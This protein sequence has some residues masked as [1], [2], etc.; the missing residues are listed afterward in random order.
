MKTRFYLFSLSFFCSM[1]TAGLSLCRAQVISVTCYPDSVIKNVS[2]HPIGIN[3]DFFMDGGR[4]PN[5]KFTVKEDIKKMGMRYLRYPGGEK[6]DTYLFSVPPYDRSLPNLARTAGIDDYPQ[7]IRKDKKGYIYDPLDF[8]EFMAICKADHAEPVIVVAADCYLLNAKPGERL[9]TKEELIKNAVEWVR[10]A[11]VKKKYGIKYWMIGNESWNANNQNSNVNIYAQD[12]IDFSKAMKVVDPSILTI[13]NGSSDTFFK[14]VI[15]TAGDYFDRLCVSNYG[16]E[17]FFNGYNTYKDTTQNLIK[18]TQ[19][20][21]EAMNKYSTKDQ[22]KKFNL[23]VAEFGSID[24]ANHWKGTNDIGHAIVVFDMAGQLIMQ[25]KVEYSCF[26]NTRWIENGS[27]ES[28]DHDALDK[29]GNINPTGMALMIWGNYI[30]KKM[31]KISSPSPVISYACT[32]ENKLLLFFI[33]KSENIQN[34]NISLEDYKVKTVS[35]SWEYYGLNADDP[36]PIWAKKNVQNKNSLTLK[37]FSISVIEFKI[38]S[39]KIN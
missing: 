31:V 12:V 9:S 19:I 24:W 34:I 27:G 36:H 20:A 8:D 16:V 15:Q 2:N 35:Q 39:L 11:N 5:A 25:P 29:D 38:D 37:P 22:L 13:A 26:W 23:I 6:S 30:G 28:K 33:N 1:L 7:V 18:P 14:T 32:D 21:L 4:F 10:Y 3:L 17:K